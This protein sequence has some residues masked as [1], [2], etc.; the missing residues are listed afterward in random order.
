MAFPVTRVFVPCFL[1]RLELGF[2]AE[3]SGGP[4]LKQLF[5]SWKQSK[6]GKQGGDW[7]AQDWVAHHAFQSLATKDGR[8]AEQ[9]DSR[10]S[11]EPFAC[12]GCTRVARDPL[13]A[14]T[15]GAIRPEV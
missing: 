9:A 6:Q 12:G 7:F 1:P 5:Q 2:S 11:S 10:V 13:E 8:E 4:S 3:N 14:R 15:R